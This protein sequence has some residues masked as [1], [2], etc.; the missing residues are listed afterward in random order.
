MSKEGL[1][2]LVQQLMELEVSEKV[3]TQRYQRSASR[4]T[5]RNGYRA[6][7]CGV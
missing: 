4:T 6:R 7:L 5:H 2:W 3:G 1:R